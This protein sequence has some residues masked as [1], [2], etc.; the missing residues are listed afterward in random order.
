MTLRRLSEADLDRVRSARARNP[1]AIG[2]AAVGRVFDR[3]DGDR[4]APASI[5]V[6]TQLLVRG[7]GEIRPPHAPRG[8]V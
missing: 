2:R 3:I 5:V 4:S 6:P 8:R 1:E 7:S